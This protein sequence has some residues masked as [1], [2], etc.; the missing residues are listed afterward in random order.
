[1]DDN[2]NDI[3]SILFGFPEKRLHTSLHLRVIDSAQ[4][5]RC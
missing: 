4:T 2:G 5:E 3:G 1:M